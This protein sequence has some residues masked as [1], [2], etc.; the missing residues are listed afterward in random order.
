MDMPNVPRS[1]YSLVYEPREDTYLLMD[2]LQ[3]QRD[4]LMALC[5]SLSLEIGPGSGV[6]SAFL[7]TLL[8]PLP[9][10]LLGADINKDAARITR[11]VGR[12]SFFNSNRSFFMN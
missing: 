3:N 7:A 4:H 5:P 8:A 1:C 12:I 10:L 6:V 9:L 11:Q 2:A